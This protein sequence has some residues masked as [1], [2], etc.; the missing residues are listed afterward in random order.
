MV[1][2]IMGFYFTLRL[3]Q[4]VVPWVMRSVGFTAM[5]MWTALSSFWVGVPQATHRIA[6]EWA[7]KAFDAGIPTNLDRRL[8]YAIR[9]AAFLTIV[10]GW[11]LLSFFTVWIVKR[12][13]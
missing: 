13:F 6:D 8:Y 12:I 3:L 5:M 4:L 1:R 11:I 7:K 9:V 10:L 2:I